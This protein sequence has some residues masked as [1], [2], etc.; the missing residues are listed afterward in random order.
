M[1]NFD[2]YNVL[3]SIATNIA[4]LLM[5]VSVLQ[6][7]VYYRSSTNI[8]LA[9]SCCICVHLIFFFTICCTFSNI[10]KGVIG[11]KISFSSCLNINVCWECV[12]IHPIMIQI[13]SVHPFY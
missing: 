8:F 5:T 11:C 13:H 10:F 3:L 1:Y 9:I 7:H 4:V 12:H 6:G 2:P